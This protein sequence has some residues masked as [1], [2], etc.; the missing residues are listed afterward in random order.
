VNAGGCARCHTIDGQG[1]QIG[2][3]LSLVAR[4]SNRQ[5]LAESILRPSKEIAPQYTTWSLVTR[6]G[7]AH[8]GLLLAEDRRGNV[9]LGTAEGQIEELE[10]AQIEER[11]AQTTSVMPERLVDLLTPA[12]FRDLIAYLASLK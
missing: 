1:G 9:R 12:E 8:T 7:R 2:P 10:G 5:K 6:D 4:T 3:D 11:R